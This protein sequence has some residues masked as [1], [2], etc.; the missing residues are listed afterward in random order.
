MRVLIVA[1]GASGVSCG[2]LLSFRYYARQIILE[3]EYL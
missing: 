3:A 1:P 2:Q